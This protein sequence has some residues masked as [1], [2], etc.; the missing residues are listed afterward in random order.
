VKTLPVKRIPV[1]AGGKEYVTGTVTE[2]TG[3]TLP[4]TARWALSAEDAAPATDASWTDA[5]VE[6]IAPSQLR[7]RALVGPD[8]AAGRH[9]VWIR[10]PDDPED[11]ILPL[12]ALVLY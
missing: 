5:V 8:R 4:T 7:V 10:I 2:T 1:S 9:I 12:C 3:K 6:Q 11:L